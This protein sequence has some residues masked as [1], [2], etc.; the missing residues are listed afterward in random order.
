MKPNLQ[1]INDA[2]RVLNEALQ[3]DPECV[4]QLMKLEVPVNGE[5]ARHPT[6]QVGTSLVDPER[7]GYVVRPL[8]LINGLFGTFG[9]DEWGYIAMHQKPD[10]SIDKFSTAYWQEA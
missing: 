2:V 7:A 3:A 5:L 9:E 6:I 4:N 8:G 10:G 1:A